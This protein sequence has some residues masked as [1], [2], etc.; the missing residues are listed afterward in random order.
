MSTGWRSVD[1]K[2][3]YFHSSGNMAGSEWVQDEKSKK[4]YY[5]RSSGNWLYLK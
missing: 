1:G 4:W 5:L 2:I 3:Y